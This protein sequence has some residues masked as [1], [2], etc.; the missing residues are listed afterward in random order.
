MSHY[1]NCTHM[2]DMHASTKVNL[3]SNETN[4]K[5]MSHELDSVPSMVTRDIA[6]LH[7]PLNGHGFGALG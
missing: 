3:K 5:L 6:I 4:N 7:T 2:H 1:V